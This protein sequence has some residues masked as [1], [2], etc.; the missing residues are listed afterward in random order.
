MLMISK[1]QGATSTA[2]D[3]AKKG[4]KGRLEL[5]ALR[6]G[7]GYRVRFEDYGNYGRVRWQ[8]DFGQLTGDEVSSM[9][10]ALLDLLDGVTE[11]TAVEFTPP[12]PEPEVEAEAVEVA[13]AEEPVEETEA[14]EVAPEAVVAESDMDQLEA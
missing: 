6:D 7:D 11:T 13:P 9:I 10:N 4:D 14:P 12:A 2:G 5:K 3:K 8:A 1:K